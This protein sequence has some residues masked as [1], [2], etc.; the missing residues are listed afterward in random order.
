MNQKNKFRP[1]DCSHVHLSQSNSVSLNISVSFLFLEASATIGF[2]PSPFL[3]AFFFLWLSFLSCCPLDSPSSSHCSKM[4]FS[5]GDHPGPSL[6]F[7][8]NHVFTPAFNYHLYISIS[9]Q[10][11]HL[12]LG[13]LLWVHCCQLLIGYLHWDVC[14]VPVTE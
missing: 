12:Q 6:S 3:L 13:T 11:I 14:Y 5:L 1:R 4:T 8:D 2:W 10:L 7:W 9:V